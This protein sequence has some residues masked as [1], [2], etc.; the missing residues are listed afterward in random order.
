MKTLFI[1]ANLIFVLY[2]SF[3]WIKYGVQKSI[4]NSY[5]VLPRNINFLF[6]FFCW[7]FALPVIIIGAPQTPLMFFA[8]AGI[9]FVGAAAQ[10]KE[11]FVRRFHVACA[12]IAIALSQIAIVFVYDMW[13][14]TLICAL[15]LL[16]A[17]FGNKKT[18]IWWMEI[19]CFGEH[20]RGS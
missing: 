18:W 8:G 5:Y 6:T 19:V 12:V 10:I 20:R 2:V 15:L 9:C 7:G 13:F 14:M 3:I 16:I 17:Y 4:S 1:I 11:E